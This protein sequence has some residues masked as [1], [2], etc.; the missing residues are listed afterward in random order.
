M[1]KLPKECFECKSVN[2]NNY[3]LFIVDNAAV[4]PD[5]VI[6][7]EGSTFRSISISDVINFVYGKNV[8]IIEQ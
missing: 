2:K 4:F 7:V 1:Q 5:N 6:S 8:K 3:K